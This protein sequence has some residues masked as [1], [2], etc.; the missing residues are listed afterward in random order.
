ME[1]LFHPAGAAET[2]TMIQ[3]SR[4]IARVYPV[5]SEQEAKEI[6]AKV[7]AIHQDANHNVFAYRIGPVEKCSDDGEPSGTAGRPALEGLHKACLDSILVVITRYFGGIKL[8]AG[9][10]IR[11]YAQAARSAM[12]KAGRLRLVP[13]RQLKITMDYNLLNKIRH[14]VETRGYPAPQIRY[15]DQVE[16]TL[17]IPSEEEGD[18][19]GFVDW[20]T[21]IGS[22]TLG[23]VVG[24]LVLRPEPV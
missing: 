23:I 4:F 24:E 11:A 8:G 1:R 22:G 13:H 19:A 9:G 18:V 3:K 14:E 2:E 16:V 5:S 17:L 10:L 21:E 20:L 15:T 7:R 6:L 12:D